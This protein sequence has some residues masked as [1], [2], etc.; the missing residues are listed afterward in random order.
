MVRPTARPPAPPAPPPPP[1][2]FPFPDLRNEQDYGTIPKNVVELS[3]DS[4]QRELRALRRAVRHNE[5]AAVAADAAAAAGAARPSLLRRLGF[6][7]G[8]AARRWARQLPGPHQPQGW[9]VLSTDSLP[10]STPATGSCPS[11]CLQR[12]GAG[13]PLAGGARRA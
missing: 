3:L 10:R 8:Q 5:L 13:R 4:F 11:R 2:R 1:P 9:A 12:A 6:A 7:V